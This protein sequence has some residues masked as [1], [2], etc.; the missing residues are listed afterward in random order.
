MC[1]RNVLLIMMW[2]VCELVLRMGN[3][4]YMCVW[5]TSIYSKAPQAT[6]RLSLRKY[7]NS[8]RTQRL[9][10]AAIW[11]FERILCFHKT[12]ALNKV[13]SFRI[14]IAMES[15]TNRTYRSVVRCLFTRPYKSLKLVKR[16]KWCVCIGLARFLRDWCL[17]ASKEWWRCDDFRLSEVDCHEPPSAFPM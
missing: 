3:I 5:A 11:G 16:Y 6:G 2:T 10:V 8:G 9:C 1:V 14:M 4:V 17:D 7:T 12:A 13:Q 15:F